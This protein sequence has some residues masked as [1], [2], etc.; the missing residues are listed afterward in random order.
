MAK[1]IETTQAD[2]VT[3][4]IRQ[5]DFMAAKLEESRQKIEDCI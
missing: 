3:T 2:R 5:A 1:R 4:L